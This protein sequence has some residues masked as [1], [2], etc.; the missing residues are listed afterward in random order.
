M[1]ETWLRNACVTVESVHV[2][3]LACAQWSAADCV[4]SLVG[5]GYWSVGLR[6]HSVRS[7]G[8]FAGSIGSQGRAHA[9]GHIARLW[10]CFVSGLVADDSIGLARMPLDCI[11]ALP[12]MRIYSFEPITGH[13]PS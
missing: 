7:C 9:I 10:W 11:E 2:P 3:D 1:Q 13:M 6:G 8:V 5:Y 12:S 4:Q